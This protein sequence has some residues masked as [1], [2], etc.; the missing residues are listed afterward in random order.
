[1]LGKITRV[2][3]FALFLASL[4][5]A[6]FFCASASVESG[7]QTVYHI[8]NP[9]AN[10]DWASYGQYKANLHTHS[11][12]SDGDHSTSTMVEAYYAKGYDILAMTDH[13]YLTPDWDLVRSGAVSPERKNEIQAGADRGGRSMTGIENTNEQSSVNHINTFW[14]PFNN[15]PHATMSAIIGKA[16]ELGGISHINHPGR[17]TGGSKQKDTASIAASNKPGMIQKYVDLFMQYPSCVGLEIVNRLDNHS[18]A[19]RILWDNILKETMPAGRFVWGFANDDAHRLTDIGYS[20][21]VLLMPS[22]HQAEIRKAME[23]GAFYAVSRVSRLDNINR[24]KPNGSEMPGY[25]ASATQYLLE[26]PTPGIVDISV[27]G[28]TI[29]IHG[30][31]YDR[32]EWIADGVVIATGNGIVLS[33]HAGRITSYIRAQ[34]MSETGI[35]FTQ[36]FGVSAAGE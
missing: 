12:I 1:M 23:T 25:G 9:Y 16:E 15:V 19:D 34:L 35:A 8:T 32:I 2:R 33:D 21:N 31:D 13:S 36:P 11:R 5:A 18:K 30:V 6:L 29:I 27:N 17:Y 22:N 14:A 4:F 24:R 7:A 3:R 26:Q 10:V 20:W 28:D